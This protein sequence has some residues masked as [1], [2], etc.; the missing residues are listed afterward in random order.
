M[1]QPDPSP[2]HNPDGSWRLDIVAALLD[3]HKGRTPDVA[4]ALGIPSGTLQQLILNHPDELSAHVNS[5]PGPASGDQT[6]GAILAAI[7]STHGGTPMEIAKATGLKYDAVYR[8][9]QRS[10]ELR[11][12][13][14]MA[15]ES[16]TDIA[17]THHAAAVRAGDD[18]HVLFRLKTQGKDR[19]YT[20]RRETEATHT[21]VHALDR[22]STQDLLAALTQTTPEQLPDGAIDAEFTIEAPDGTVLTPEDLGISNEQP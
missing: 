18:K 9:L 1:S 2:L 4:A 10:P 6:R 17:E 3:R 5:K 14:Q 20:E 12:A 16:L 7:E 22:A 8:Q 11:Q 15:R 19:G 13:Q 21:H